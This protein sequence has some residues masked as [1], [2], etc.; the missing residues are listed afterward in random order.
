M[1]YFNLDM[2]EVRYYDGMVRILKKD[3]LKKWDPTT[4]PPY[5]PRRR[6]KKQ[7]K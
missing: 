6:L 3:M 1:Y 2:Y 7:D 4:A 5:K